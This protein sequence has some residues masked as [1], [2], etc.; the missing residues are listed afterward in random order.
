MRNRFALN[1]S[2]SEDDVTWKLTK[3]SNLLRLK[4]SVCQLY[5][6]RLINE[7]LRKS[8]ANFFRAFFKLHAKCKRKILVKKLFI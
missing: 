8:C 1:L 2:I 4:Q 6:K 3:E 5:C 7:K